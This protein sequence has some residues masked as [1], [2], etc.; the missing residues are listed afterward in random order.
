LWANPQTYKQGDVKRMLLR[1]WQALDREGRVIVQVRTEHEDVARDAIAAAIDA[2]P[3][4]A[5]EGYYL[6]SNGRDLSRHC[7]CDY[8]HSRGCVINQRARAAYDAAGRRICGL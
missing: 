4:A 8:R 7:V 2:D 3:S 1:V 5:S 6:D